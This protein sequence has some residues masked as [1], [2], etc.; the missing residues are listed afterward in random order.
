MHK[1][2]D[3]HVSGH[4][5]VEDL[6]LLIAL[7]RPAYLLPIHGDHFMLRK[8]GELGAQMGIPWENNLLTENGRITEL[9]S[10]SVVVTDE[11]ITE[12]YVLVDGTGVGA[13]SEVVLEERRQMGTEGTVIVVVLVNKSKD[14]I[15]G[16]EVISRGFVY[17][18][19]S[20]DL[21][22]E[23]RDYVKANFKNIKVDTTSKTYWTELRNGVRGLTRD[24]LN[25]RLEKDPMVIPVVVQV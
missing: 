9:N 3:L 16:P 4:A 2:F 21:F 13:V 18:K 19:N 11:F 14:L 15:G 7:A 10:Q 12:N 1:E 17:M 22:D 6:K 20:T 23:L 24:F 8:V 5:C 25:N